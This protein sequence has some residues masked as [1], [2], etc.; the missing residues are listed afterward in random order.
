MKYNKYI[1]GFFTGFV[2]LTGIIP[3]WLLFKPSVKLEDGAKRR[4][5]SPCI[6]VSNHT[7]LL[8]FVLYLI[9]FPF[10]TIHFLMAEVLFSKNA[11]LRVFLLLLG[12][13]KVDRDSKNF[14]FVSD[15]LE[16]LDNKGTVGIFPQG[17]L[18]VNSK[19]FPFTVSTA[20]IATHTDAPIVPVYT[21]GNYGIFKR[22][23]VVIGKP[24]Y[25][26]DYRKEGLTDDEQLN[27]LTQVLEEK[28]YSLKDLLDKDG[29]NADSKQ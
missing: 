25:L 20:F 14:D 22:A 2:K 1:V 8:D 27:Y 18:P 24:I 7:S 4:L 10:R 23:K 19:P 28:V 3:A 21:H 6:M 17:R 29:K 9:V 15:A 12:G 16:V 11:F 13:I 5:K 26:S